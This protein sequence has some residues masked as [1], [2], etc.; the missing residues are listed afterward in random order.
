MKPRAPAN[1]WW[2]LV[3][4]HYEAR[5]EI[6]KGWP[7]LPDYIQLLK[8]VSLS[9]YAPLVRPWRLLDLLIL[10]RESDGAPRTTIDTINIAPRRKLGIARFEGRP[11]GRQVRVEQALCNYRDAWPHLET[12]LRKL[13]IDATST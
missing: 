9:C 1:V 2:D 3:I 10:A 13:L 8:Q 6:V 11:T 4:R 5:Q 12:Q 7:E